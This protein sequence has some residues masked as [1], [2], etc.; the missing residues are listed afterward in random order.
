MATACVTQAERLWKF[1]SLKRAGERGTAETNRWK[2]N[3]ETIAWIDWH[4]SVSLPIAQRRMHRKRGKNCLR[5]CVHQMMVISYYDIRASIA[6]MQ[7]YILSYSS[8]TVAGFRLQLSACTSRE[9]RHGRDELFYEYF[10]LLSCSFSN[11]SFGS[12]RINKKCVEFILL[13]ATVRGNWSRL[14]Y[15]AR[16]RAFDD[17]YEQS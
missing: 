10:Q 8:S 11:N 4:R 6:V 14:R 17:R 9:S 15:F 12:V 1:R 13:W 7:I 3:S 2:G 5:Q 16:N